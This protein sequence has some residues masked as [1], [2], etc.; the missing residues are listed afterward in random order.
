MFLLLYT[1]L[2]FSGSVDEYY[3]TAD[4]KYMVA[5]LDTGEVHCMKILDKERPDFRQDN[6]T[7][8][9]KFPPV[10]SEVLVVKYLISNKF[11]P[12]ISLLK[13]QPMS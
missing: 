2:S 12:P 11:V 6:D 13:K 10:P 5:T 1:Y 7:F 4:E 3:T 8:L 9:S